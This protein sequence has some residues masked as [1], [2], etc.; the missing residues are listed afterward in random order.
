MRGM[1]AEAAIDR[2][3]EQWDGGEQYVRDKAAVYRFA[4]LVFAYKTFN[5][6]TE[7]SIRE[8]EKNTAVDLTEDEV[9]TTVKE[10]LLYNFI[11]CTQS[12]SDDDD[13]VI[14]IT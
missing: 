7:E 5:A 8:M 6:I 12:S 3:F 1:E 2:D 14:F 11:D 13:E 9:V 4:S 10:N